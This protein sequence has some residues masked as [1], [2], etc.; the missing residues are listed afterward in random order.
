MVK[1]L[2]GEYCYLHYGQNIKQI[3]LKKNLFPKNTQ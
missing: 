2:S 3:N 1:T